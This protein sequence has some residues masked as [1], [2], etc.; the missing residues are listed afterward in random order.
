MQE[1][2]SELIVVIDDEALVLEA[3]HVLLETWGYR[4]LAAESERDAVERLQSLGERPTAILADYRLREGRTGLEAIERIRTV[5]GDVIPS[6][7]ITGDT[8]TE[9][10]R[11]AEASGLPVLQKPVLP[12]HLRKVLAQTLRRRGD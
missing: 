8:S 2:E 10:L 1:T 5:A 6:I 12:P 9:S 11:Q 4:V 3:L 7:I